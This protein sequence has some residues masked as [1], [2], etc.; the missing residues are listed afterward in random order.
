M[1]SAGRLI[2]RLTDVQAKDKVFHRPLTA[3]SSY[4]N[5]NHSMKTVHILLHLSLSLS[6]F[7]SL[8]RSLSLSLSLSRFMLNTSQTRSIGVNLEIE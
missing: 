4:Y 6:L 5:K 1:D 7:L 8:A 3:L 2:S